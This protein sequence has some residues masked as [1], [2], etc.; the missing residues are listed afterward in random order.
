MPKLIT[1]LAEVDELKSKEAMLKSEQQRHPRMRQNGVSRRL[2]A[3]SG[4][5]TPVGF[6][7]S[8]DSM[9]LELAF[10]DQGGHRER[11]GSSG[12]N[13]DGSTCRWSAQR[14]AWRHRPR[15]NGPGLCD[16]KPDDLGGEVSNN[17]APSRATIWRADR[18]NSQRLQ[19]QTSRKGSRPQRMRPTSCSS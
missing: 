8:A 11:Q 1:L 13:H 5:S 6:L 3:N 2:C 10:R 17:S 9:L 19:R 18:T 16:A 4:R 15:G 14:R 7:P 12:G